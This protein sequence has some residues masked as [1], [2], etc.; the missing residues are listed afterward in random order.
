MPKP[1][2]FTGLSFLFYINFLSAN[3]IIDSSQT[4]IQFAEEKIYGYKIPSNFFKRYLIRLSGHVY[5]RYPFLLS[6]FR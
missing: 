1:F 4:T 2:D 3:G 6:A 5:G